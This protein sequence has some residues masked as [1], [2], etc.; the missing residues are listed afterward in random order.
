MLLLLSV[1]WQVCHFMF[2][3]RLGFRHCENAD[4][5]GVV[6]LLLVVLLYIFGSV[7]ARDRRSSTRLLPPICWYVDGYICPILCA[8]LSRDG[9]ASTAHLVC[10]V[11]LSM[12]RIC[13]YRFRA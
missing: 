10:S 12:R 5:T 11:P 3:T 4:R 6:A 2:E 9:F 13:C 1:L 7:A 8:S